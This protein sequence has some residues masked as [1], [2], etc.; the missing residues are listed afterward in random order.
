M[1]TAV[2]ATHK[3][4]SVRAVAMILASMGSWSLRGIEISQRNLGKHAGVS[5][6]S[7]SNSIGRLVR[8]GHVKV[9]RRSPKSNGHDV[10][11]RP[12]AYRLTIPEGPTWS[13]ADTGVI[14]WGDESPYSVSNFSQ[15]TS[16]LHSDGPRYADDG[17]FPWARSCSEIATRCWHP[18]DAPP[19]ASSTAAGFCS[20]G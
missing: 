13:V 4:P 7:V 9:S 5:Q 8:T 11:Q 19:R 2:L 18:P 6:R 15:E 16:P 17:L 1:T 10:T 14:G 3:A 20:W 12:D